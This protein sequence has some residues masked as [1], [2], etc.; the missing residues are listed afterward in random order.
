MSIKKLITE[1]NFRRSY[2]ALHLLSVSTNLSESDFVNILF[3]TVIYKNN[4]CNLP[5]NIILPFL[6]FTFHFSIKIFFFVSF[7]VP[8]SCLFI[9]YCSH[10]IFLFAA[11]LC[12][13]SYRKNNFFILQKLLWNECLVFSSSYKYFNKAVK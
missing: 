11:A 3:I 4:R 9:I 5:E 12:S 10:H 7:F 1:H 6:V 2:Y 13:Y 8:Y